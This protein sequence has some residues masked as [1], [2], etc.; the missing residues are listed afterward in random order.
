MY[1][2]TILENP[3]Q[4]FIK[5]INK[6]IFS[7]IWGNRERIKRN[8]L[9]RNINEG[10]IGITDFESKLK[11]IKASWVL[12][13]IQNRSSLS[14]LLNAC[15]VKHNI[16]IPF[17]LNSSITRYEEFKLNSLPVFYKEVL[18]AFNECK[19]ISLTNFANQNIWFNKKAYA[20][21]VNLYFFQVG[22]KVVYY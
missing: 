9:I 3:E 11:A 6:I 21:R 14:S 2:A 1:T 16:D 17:L 10:G 18:V 13:I 12:K 15:V 7:F 22:L 4:S 20:L 19:D 5:S 8:T